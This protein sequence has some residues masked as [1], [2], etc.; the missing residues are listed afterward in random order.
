MI[1][2]TIYAALVGTSLLL[3]AGNSAANA[4]LSGLLGMKATPMKDSQLSEVKGKAH[5]GFPLGALLINRANEKL[6]TTPAWLSRGL[7][8]GQG[9][10]L[11][12][13]SDNV[14]GGRR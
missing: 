2:N 7:N 10:A 4:D 8:P 13:A 11:N 12:R 3:T 6:L 5:D 14:G 9:P 1:K